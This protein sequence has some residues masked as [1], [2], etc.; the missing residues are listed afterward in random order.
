MDS[1]NILNMKSPMYEGVLKKKTKTDDKTL[2]RN[3]QRS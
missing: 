2:K 3:T 1:K